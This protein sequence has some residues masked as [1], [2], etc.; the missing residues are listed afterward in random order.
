MDIIKV[1]IMD[2]SPDRNNLSNSFFGSLLL[3]FLY[4]YMA[5]N[6]TGSIANIIFTINTS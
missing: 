6:T 4:M 5:I 2:R 1:N 3:S